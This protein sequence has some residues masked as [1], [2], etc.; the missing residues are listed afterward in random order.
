MNI[1]GKYLKVWKVKESPGGYTRLDLG[2]SKKDKSGNYVN[3]TW[4][5]CMLL[6][7]AKGVK[8]SEGDKVEVKNG[9][10]Y[11]EKYQNKWYTK[12]IIFDLEVMES[13]QDKQAA[14]V[15]EVFEDDTI[16]F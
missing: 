10:I 3:W 4:F 12:I 13:G 9:I 11:Q 8:V 7:D 16:P 15:K 2:D 1:S 5:D 14:L 6:G